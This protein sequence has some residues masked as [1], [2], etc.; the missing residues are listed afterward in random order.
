M[1]N[2]RERDWKQAFSSIYKNGLRTDGRTDAEWVETVCNRRIQFVDMN[3][4]PMSSGANERM[5]AA[6]R[7]SEASSAELAN[8]WAARANERAAQ[9]SPRWFHSHF[10]HCGTDRR[11]DGHARTQ[12]IPRK[13]NQHQEQKDFLFLIALIFLYRSLYLI[14]KIC[15]WE[16]TIE[17]NVWNHRWTTSSTAWQQ[18]QEQQ[19]QQEQEQQEQQ[20]Q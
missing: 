4:S 19:E 3:L 12:N 17:W 11:M 14:A 1:H 6:E 2:A 13:K 8:E 18:Q 15:A 9:Y 20:Q 5:S 7:V 10:T 16:W